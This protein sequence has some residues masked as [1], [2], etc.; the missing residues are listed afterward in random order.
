MTRW[1]LAIALAVGLVGLAPAPAFADWYFGA[2]FGRAIPPSGGA[3]ERSLTL[4]VGSVSNHG[5]LGAEADYAV[6]P[7][8]ENGGEARTLTGS[9]L[10]GKKTGSGWR[11][12]GSFG[13]GHLGP[14]VTFSDN[15]RLYGQTAPQ[16]SVI[17]F[18]G[19]VMGDFSTHFG[20]RA[21]VRVFKDLTGQT[22][23][24]PAHL[25]FTRIAVGVYLNF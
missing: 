9:L 2:G 1:T 7:T 19:G 22:A 17:T 4:D 20:A 14:V 21:D 5:W 16:K 11:P 6:L 10:V 3:A 24:I 12:Y 25:T 8:L 15:F 23:G 13:F 18:G